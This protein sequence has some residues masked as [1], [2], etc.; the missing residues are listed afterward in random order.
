MCSLMS[1]GDVQAKSPF[2]TAL[3]ES[4]PGTPPSMCEYSSGPDAEEPVSVLL[5]ATQFSDAG[6]ANASLSN[7]RQAAVDAGIPVVDIPGLGEKAHASGVDEVGVHAV[8]GNRLIDANLGGE[9]PD[10]TDEAKIAAGT[11]LI[12][13]IL[14]RLP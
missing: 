11:E 8:V 9:W 7:Q 14:S 12:R 6:Q 4:E 1:L 2:Q 10:T 5:V 3:A 13:T